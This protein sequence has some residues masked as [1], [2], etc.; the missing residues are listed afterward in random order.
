[1]IQTAPA[2]R[3]ASLRLPAAQRSARGRL[4]LARNPEF[5]GCQHEEGHRIGRENVSSLCYERGLSLCPASTPSPWMRALHPAGDAG[6]HKTP[7]HLNGTGDHRR[8]DFHLVGQATHPRCPDAENTQGTAQVS[9]GQSHGGSR[10]KG[11]AEA[12]ALPPSQFLNTP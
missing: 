3:S 1:M 5:L 7:V 4:S 2:W 9:F 11:W 8:M 6:V 10:P 12:L